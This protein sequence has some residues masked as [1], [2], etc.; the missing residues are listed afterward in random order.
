MKRILPIV[1][2][3]VIAIV[4]Y[5]VW[6][7]TQGSSARGAGLGGSGTIEATNVTV[8]SQALSS[9]RITSARVTA[10]DAVK[11]GQLLFTLDPTLARYQVQQAQ[12]GVRAAQATLNSDR[13][14]GKSD[15]QIAQD[16]A[17][18]DQAR[19]AVRI[20]Q[21]QAAYSQVKAPISG[22]A[23]DVP[24]TVGE[25]AVPGGTLA[26]LGDVSHLTVSIYV[27]ESQ[28]G[29]VKVGQKGSLTTDS[30][31]AKKFDVT[32][33]AVASQAEFTPASIET[34]DQRVKLVYE[35][36]LDVSDSTGT[37]KPGMPADVTL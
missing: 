24:A 29:Q 8:S 15:S 32:V 12:A 31:G 36:K 5:A 23:L 21:T 1:A 34:K 6:T 27:P 16:V 4:A 11:K 10:G 20:A 9:A 26:V 2:V 28:I 35:V 22:V 37:L 17:Q 13:D 7:T 19:I 33:T 25:N 14:N 18:R 3:V 30:T